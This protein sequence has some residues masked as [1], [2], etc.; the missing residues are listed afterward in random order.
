MEARLWLDGACEWDVPSG[1]P[2]CGFGGV[3]FLGKEIL[4]WGFELPRED[5]KRWAERVGK[6]QLVFECELLPYLIFLQLWGALLKGCDLMIFID[7]DAARASLAKS[8]TRKEEGARIVFKAVEAE[9]RLDVQAFFMRAPA[10]SNIADGPSRGDFSVV[11]RMGGRRVD[12]PPM[13]SSWPWASSSKRGGCVRG[14]IIEIH[15]VSRRVGVAH[16][17]PAVVQ[18]ESYPTSSR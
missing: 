8:S 10:A 2:V 1:S 12:L 9:E 5:G 17:D 3:L 11:L 4:A 13:Q 15:L 14:S 7:N 16:S 18:P 6:Q